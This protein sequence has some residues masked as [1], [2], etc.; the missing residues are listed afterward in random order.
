[1]RITIFGSGYVGLVTGACFANVGNQVNYRNNPRADQSTRILEED[2]QHHS[3]MRQATH[4]CQRYN[5]R[6]QEMDDD[7]RRHNQSK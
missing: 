1:M 5:Q 4:D 2:Q 7:K 3:L 6:L